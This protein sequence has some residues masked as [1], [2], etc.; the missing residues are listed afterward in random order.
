MDKA[1]KDEGRAG[2][3]PVDDESITASGTL[4]LLSR[5]AMNTV[6]GRRISEANSG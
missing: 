4:A 5:H 2:I 1:S 6:P 3:L